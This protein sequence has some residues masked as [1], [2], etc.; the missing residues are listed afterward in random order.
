MKTRIPFVPINPCD[1]SVALCKNAAQYKKKTKI[2][3]K[4]GTLQTTKWLAV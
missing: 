3:Q 1:L 4:T 2:K